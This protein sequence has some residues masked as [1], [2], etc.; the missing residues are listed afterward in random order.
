VARGE[1]LDTRIGIRRPGGR[2]TVRPALKADAKR[3]TNR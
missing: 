1:Q 2:A 3:L